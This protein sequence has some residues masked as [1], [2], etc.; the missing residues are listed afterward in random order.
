MNISA[1]STEVTAL[2]LEIDNYFSFGLRCAHTN[3]NL[4]FS[5][6]GVWFTYSF[7]CAWMAGNIGLSTLNAH[8]VRVYISLS[9]S[10]IGE[11]TTI[12]T[13]FRTLWRA[14]RTRICGNCAEVRS[15]AFQLILFRLNAWVIETTDLMCRVECRTWMED[16]Q[17]DLKKLV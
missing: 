16:L 11:R 12:C 9:M 6:S 4:L 3:Y 14:I 8:A 1:P 2:D 15:F 7:N 5:I 10:N 17:D 13:W